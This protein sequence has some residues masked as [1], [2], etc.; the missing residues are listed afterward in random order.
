MVNL[1]ADNAKLRDRALGIVALIAGV[2]EAQA[3]A[4]LRAAGGDVKPA[5][6]IARSGVTMS[7]AVAWLAA[8][9]GRIDD[10]LRLS[11]AAWR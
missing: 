5:I 9:Q 11:R 1:K 3:D 10:A 2:D 4:A 6:L 7:E 8:A